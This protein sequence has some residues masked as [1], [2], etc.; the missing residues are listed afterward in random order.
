MRRLRPALAVAGAAM[1]AAVAVTGCA[2]ARAASSISFASAYVPQPTTPGTTVAYLDIRNNGAADR[3]VAVHTSVGGT[4]QL[5]A[6]A[7][8]RAGA[9]LMRTVPDIPIP[10]DSMTQ[11]D[12]DGFHLLITGAG[13]MHDGKDI[14]LR[15]TFAKAGTFT[16]IAMVTD[17]E[18]G[19]S[20]YFI[21]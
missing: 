4:V 20:S 2:A 21:N 10:A 11:L 15:L 7:G 9:L 8:R 12:P 6:P 16:V 1:L 3:L 5:R 19:G 18:S 13:P 14:M 17:P